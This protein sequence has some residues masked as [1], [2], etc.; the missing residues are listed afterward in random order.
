MTTWA[1]ID[2]T[3]LRANTDV[4]RERVAPA[5]L[6]AV[7]KD[8][9][10]G[11]GL[12]EVTRALVGAGVTAFG[13]LDPHTALRVRQLAP[14][15]TVFA[16]LFDS[17]DDLAALIDA[18]IELGVTDLHTLERVGAIDRAAA[19]HLKFDSGLS[20]AGI[21]SE[22]WRDFVSR[23]AELEHAGAL[24]VVGVWT[25]ISEAS[26]VEDTASIAR[27][28]A[29]IDDAVAAGLGPTVRHLAAS[30]ASFQRA[31]ARFDRVRVGAFL[32]G[33]APGDGLGPAQLGLRPVMTLRSTVTAVDRGIATI[34][35]GG[36]AGLLT[37]AAG[38]V[39]VTIGGVRHPLI[40]V[41]DTHSL[42]DVG[43]ATVGVGDTVTLFGS[44]DSGEQTLQQWADAMG[45][46]GEELV[47][48]VHPSI[49]RRYTR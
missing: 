3:A 16:W 11:H 9:A 17:G 40:A 29:A 18:G 5:E 26:E 20:R 25:H 43:E 6:L 14:D 32:Y 36:A 4:V 22:Q 28:T 10:Y 7:V 47:T 34:D 46:I 15:S 27:F 13:A 31:D 8:D 41:H 45:T 49:E 33:I 24:R 23:A 38:T 12:D 21:R 1:E 48:R 44:G 35:Y 42:V 39:S 19:V 37:D 30:A 2:L